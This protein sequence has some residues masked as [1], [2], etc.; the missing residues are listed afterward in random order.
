MT[1]QPY[2]SLLW[3][4]VIVSGLIVPVASILVSCGG[5]LSAGRTA[6]DNDI[7]DD[8][9]IDSIDQCQNTAAGAIPGA[10]GCV[11]VEVATINS[12]LVGG[13]DTDRP[14]YT[15]YVF[16]DDQGLP[17]SACNDSCTETWP[18]L[19]VDDGF[20]TG[21][22]NLTTIVRADGTIQAAFEN[23]PLYFYSG[24]NNAGDVNGQGLN[25]AWSLV[26]YDGFQSPLAYT[27]YTLVWND[28]FS[29]SDLNL[30]DWSYEIGTGNSGWGNDELQYYRQENTRVADGVLTIEARK[31]NY[32]GSS[33]T[34]SR[35]V[36]LDKQFFRYGKIDI[37]AIMP[38]GQGMWPALWM[39]G[40]N[41]P[42]VGWPET[43]EIDIM[44]MIGGR[45]NTVF[46]T[47][48]W[49]NAGSYESYGDSTTLASG[50]LADEFHVFSIEWDSK[51]IKWYLDGKQYH[52]IDITPADL[53]EFQEEFFFIFNVAVGGRFPG[54][55]DSSTT[56]PQRMQVDYI[57]V[58]E[59]Q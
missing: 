45:E 46:G 42:T 32:L 40:Q 26:K 52:I 7:D 49:D 12:V 35:L 4:L 18:P 3:R 56:F 1:V 14:G 10:D 29:G 37:R 20:A 59:R 22:S 53:S 2:L 44:E 36:T 24:D 34:S 51:S 23:R 41:F 47:V 43:G 11:Y 30:S 48:H 19:L 57:R 16:D 17:G 15:L 13:V 27:G 8:G 39:L 50:T 55:P 38:R 6:F 31:E 28:E 21:V 25:A 9:V 54:N 5:D 33:Y 58:F